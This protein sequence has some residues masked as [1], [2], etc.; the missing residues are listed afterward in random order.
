MSARAVISGVLA[1]PPVHKT[2]S[3]GGAYVMA[4]IREGSGDATRWWTA[5]VFSESAIAG[6]EQLEVGAP[7]AVAGELDVKVYTPQG[8]GARLSLS[9]KVDA[10]LTA[11]R[12]PK[13]HREE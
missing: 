7:I 11:R 13:K 9:V 5:F 12:L 3:N 6:F 4:T 2:S 1:K 10:I 8:G